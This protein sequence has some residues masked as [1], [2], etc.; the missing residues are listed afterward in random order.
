[1]KIESNIYCLQLSLKRYYWVDECLSVSVYHFLLLGHM[2]HCQLFCSTCSP[3]SI[4][5]RVKKIVDISHLS[6]LGCRMQ[7]R[8]LILITL[9]F[10]LEGKFETQIIFLCYSFSNDHVG[11]C[12]L[13]ASFMNWRFHCFFNFHKE[14][15]LMVVELSCYPGSKSSIC[16]IGIGPLLICLWLK[17]SSP[18]AQLVII[19]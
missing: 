2:K 3:M 15:S 10:D 17:K 11:V 19:P 14:L 5:L 18:G 6:G 7:M 12:W 1:M 9:E 4:K 16:F 13:I 8:S